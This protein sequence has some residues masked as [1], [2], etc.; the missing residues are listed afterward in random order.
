MLQKPPSSGARQSAPIDLGV[1][2]RL[3]SDAAR[4]AE[5]AFLRREI[6]ARMHE[7]LDLIKIA[8]R[9]VLDAGCGEGADL[10]LLQKRFVDAGVFG[11]DAAPAMLAAAG[12]EQAAAQSALNRMLKKWLPGQ[13]AAAGGAALICGDFAE[14]P[15][16][17]K[18]VDLIWS[19]LA[20]HWHPEPHRV[21]A[22]WRRVLR[23]DGLLMFSCFGPDTFK[24]VRQAFAAADE[25]PHALAFVDMH[26]FGDMLIHAGFSTPVMDMETI[27][28]TYPSAERLL[29]DV[30]AWGGN[31]L[32]T[33]ARGLRGRAAQA[34]MR[35]ALELGRRAD[36]KL[37]L[38]FEIV[39]GHAFRPAPRVTRA[40][41]AI[42]RLD[43][44]KK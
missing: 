18:A 7:R 33:R 36:G 31:P 41:E 35:E 44:P 21:F 10:P 14:L 5:S 6:A 38:T 26:D 12:A 28:V 15:F 17:D 19:N 23:A 32:A 29:A 13:H 16:G 3:F 11:L 43:F 4:V 37:P 2:R 24:E 30:R 40:G 1:V 25:S 27:T 8:P 20:L 9:Q 34:R 39:Y 42:V 22:E